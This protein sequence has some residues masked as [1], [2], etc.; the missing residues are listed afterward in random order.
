MNKYLE[1]L[2]ELGSLDKKLRIA[3][4]LY[5]IYLI[6]RL[7]SDLPYTLYS[8]IQYRS[9]YNLEDFFVFEN[10]ISIIALI[11]I[12]LSLK[13]IVHPIDGDR[14][15]VLTR[16]LASI[17]LVHYILNFYFVKQVIELRPVN[18][19]DLPQ[20]IPDFLPIDWFTLEYNFEDFFQ[21]FYSPYDYVGPFEF[22]IALISAVAVAL[23]I[24][25]FFVYLK[26]SW[27]KS[28][29]QLDI[30]AIFR[31]FKSKTTRI[32]VILI[33]IPFLAFGSM[34]IQEQDFYS[35]SLDTEMTQEDLV[36]FKNKVPSASAGLSATEVIQQRKFAANSAYKVMVE[37]EEMLTRESISFWSPD[38]KDLRVQ[39]LEWVDL[40]KIVLKE[41]ALNGYAEKSSVFEL[42]QKYK[43]ISGVALNRAPTLTESFTKDFWRD[44]FV[45]LFTY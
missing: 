42:Q 45:S 32:L 14:E 9:F 25:F 20:R 3:I 41:L 13:N 34:N 31:E 24:V 16:N 10:F 43:E 37:N 38:T 44:E 6:T 18:A 8:L 2:R 12:Y 1:P 22:F 39:L 21:E 23:A 28:H 36:E 4:S 11:A 5:A 27:N 35:I 40:W 7:L 17:G 15:S 26:S 19:R 30:S 33:L 29:F